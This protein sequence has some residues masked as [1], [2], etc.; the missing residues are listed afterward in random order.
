VD[1]G[2][3]AYVTGHTTSKRFPTA[4]PFQAARGGPSC[5]EQFVWECTDAFVAKLDPAGSALVYSTYLGGADHDDAWAIA[6]D[7]AGQAHVAGSTRSADFPLANPVKP[8][9][10]G[11]TCASQIP[12]EDLFVTRLTAAGS[13]LGYSTYLGGNSRDTAFGIAIGGGAVYVTGQTS[14]PDFPTVAAVQPGF[15]GPATTPSS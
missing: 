15:G 14:S 5:P 4:S 10:G 3:A 7:G 12:C 11:G 1:A 8:I 13:A 2:G 9:I 6:V